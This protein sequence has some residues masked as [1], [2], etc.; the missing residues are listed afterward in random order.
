MI[1]TQSMGTRTLAFLFR[2]SFF[3]IQN[4]RLPIFGHADIPAHLPANLPGKC[5]RRLLFT[6]RDE[7]LQGGTSLAASC[8]T[9]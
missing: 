9:V 7:Q 2:P 4:Y 8:R 5:P 1:P 3:A 6:V